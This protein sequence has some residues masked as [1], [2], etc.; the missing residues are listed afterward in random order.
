MSTP[1][2]QPSMLAI[3]EESPGQGGKVQEPEQGREEESVQ[4]TRGGS[5]LSEEEQK[6]KRQK[7]KR[8]KEESQKI[9]FAWWIVGILWICKGL[10]LLVDYL[11]GTGCEDVVAA[12]LVYMVLLVWAITLAIKKIP[13]LLTCLVCLEPITFI[14]YIS[15][16]FDDINNGF[17]GRN[18]F[19][20]IK[21]VLSVFAL[22]FG[23]V[24]LYTMR[25]LLQ[26]LYGGDKVADQ[27]AENL[28]KKMVAG[29]P[30][31]LYLAMRM[32]SSIVTDHYIKEK[33]CGENGYITGAVPTEASAHDGL[34]WKR[35]SNCTNSEQ[36]ERHYKKIPREPI[37]IVIHNQYNEYI[38]HELQR[39]VAYFQILELS[40][41]ILSW[42]IL[43]KRLWNLNFKT[44]VACQWKCF[45]FVLVVLASLRIG[46]TLFL[47]ILT[48]H[49]F[50]DHRTYLWYQE[51]S[52][53]AILGLYIL[54][55]IL[56]LVM[57]QFAWSRVPT[58]AQRSGPPHTE[59]TSVSSGNTSAPNCASAIRNDLKNRGKRPSASPRSLAHLQPSNSWGMS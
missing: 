53:Y 19:Y 22:G 47:S 5:L 20:T 46:V 12:V 34:N 54:F 41:T 15:L 51:A 48:Y 58:P 10:A 3:N 9:R 1:R 14:L 31:V 35:F 18:T 16:I 21:G 29:L 6:E 38:A 33:L 50:D 4:G 37:E 26:K 56:M 43:L 28:S 30:A 44:F 55:F 49:M 27:L 57:V 23:Y 59:L 40:V 24:N 45:E 8:Q 11:T 25:P 39:T 32:V 2:H 13:R 36:F 7:E 52:V 17:D 42:E